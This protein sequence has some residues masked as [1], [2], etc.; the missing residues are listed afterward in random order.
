MIAAAAEEDATRVRTE[1]LAYLGLFL[2]SC[3]WAAAF[4][5]GKIALR[6]MSPNVTAIWRYVLATLVLLPWAAA[7]RPRWATVRE[8]LVPLA[9]MILCGGVLYQTVFLLALQHTT[10]TNTSLLIALNPIFTLLMSPLIGERIDISRWPG[11]LVA[12]AGAAVVI[13]HG[14]WQQ[15]VAFA[16]FSLS[17]GDWLAL[18][19]ALLWAGVNV[20]AQRVVHRVPAAFTN[21]LV[22]GVGALSLGLLAIPEH[23]IPQ[24][25]GASWAA[26][27]GVAV[28]GIGSSALA[29]QWFLFGLRTVG[30]HRAVVFIYLV[31]VLTALFSVAFLGESFHVSQVIGGSAV[32]TGVYWANRK[33]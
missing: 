25:L 9:V 3:A 26:L 17:I 7:Q 32:L 15:A 16:H 12:L 31:P 8:L 20:A 14:N 6:E 19:A 18:F 22:Y 30:I 11:V 13:T 5:A 4:V 1:S 2:A 10:A 24:L 21:V 28:M 29:G 27:G 33:A 23:P